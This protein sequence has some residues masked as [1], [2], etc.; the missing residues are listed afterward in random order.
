MSGYLGIDVSKN[1]LVLVR[2]AVA[3]TVSYSNDASG[4]RSLVKDLL[5]ND[6]TR[7]ILIVLEATGGYERGVVVA[8]A[9]AGL[10]VVVVNPR[11]VRDFAK[12]TG[13]L[14]KT[15]QIDARVLADFG[16]M[17]KPELKAMPGELEEE[18]R[19]LI[20]RRQQLLQMLVA[21]KSRLQQM[22][23]RSSQKLRREVRSH[24]ADLERR[25]KMTDSD[26]DDTLRKSPI[27]REQ[28]DILQSFPGIGQ[29]TSLMLLAELREIGT[30]SS[31]EIANLAG[32][33][34]VNRD[35]GKWRGKRRTGGGR[36]RVR[37]ALYMAALSA[38][39]FNP[40]IKA[41][42]CRLVSSGKPKMV[43]LVASMRKILITLNAMIKTKTRWQAH[44][45][46]AIA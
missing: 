46:P 32:L 41:Y 12:A 43:A 37:A 9:E 40:I 16:A 28:D 25:L 8:L 17:V 31:S 33:A 5:R 10:P 19:A 21:E 42:Y 45:T 34:P 1:E 6:A 4:H 3:G 15:D 27:W 35:S 7:P 14:A 22:L 36:S 24:V 11:Q 26:M 38:V 39:R 30:L 18:L 23:G 44:V 29:K 2:E 20:A 13:K